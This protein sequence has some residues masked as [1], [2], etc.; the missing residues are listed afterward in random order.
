MDGRYTW[1][2]ACIEE[3]NI[4][5][6]LLEGKIERLIDGMLFLY[7][8]LSHP[9]FSCSFK[10]FQGATWRLSSTAVEKP[11]QAE[12]MIYEII[13]SDSLPLSKLPPPSVEVRCPA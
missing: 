9:L 10:I 7:V 11:P 5:E 3:L 13:E 6:G 2:K 4:G 12:A 1:L 8:H